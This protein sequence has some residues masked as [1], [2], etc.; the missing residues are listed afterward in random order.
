MNEAQPTNLDTQASGE[1]HGSLVAL[2]ER[3]V[4]ESAAADGFDAA[5]W[6]STWLKEPVPSLGGRQTGCSSPRRGLSGAVA[7]AADAKEL[8]RLTPAGCGRRSPI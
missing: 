8:I 7:A 4:T 5:C 1:V 2:V 6:P 3:T